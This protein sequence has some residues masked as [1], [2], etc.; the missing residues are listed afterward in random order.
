ME[1]H[2]ITSC[3]PANAF[4]MFNPFDGYILEKFLTNN[5]RVFQEYESVLAYAND[6]QRS[7]LEKL[8]FVTDFR[9]AT[10]CIS[11]HTYRRNSAQ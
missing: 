5:M 3:P 9:D 11:L 10:R 8:G 6:V 7:T 4:F 2:L 1:M